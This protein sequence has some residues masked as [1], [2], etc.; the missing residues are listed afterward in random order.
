MI[1]TSEGSP[2]LLGNFQRLTFSN[3]VW[4]LG[5]S[6]VKHGSMQTAADGSYSFTP[7]AGS[8]GTLRPCVHVTDGVRNLHYYVNAQIEAKER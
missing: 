3:P 5:V 1:T 6:N 7:N 8:A 4:V 2:G